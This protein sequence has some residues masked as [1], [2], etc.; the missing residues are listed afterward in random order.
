VIRLFGEITAEDIENE[1]HA[2][3]ILCNGKCKFVVEVLQHGWLVDMSLYFIDMELCSETLEKRIETINS[4][5]NEQDAVTGLLRIA[6]GELSTSEART[7]QDQAN[8]KGEEVPS[9]Y[10]LR[11]RV[12]TDD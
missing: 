8:P 4:E 9:F 6:G 7:L 11:E 10:E 3:S 1:A 2:V 5:M 12:L